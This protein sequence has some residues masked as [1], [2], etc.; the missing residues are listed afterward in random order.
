MKK[1][2]C[3]G[4]FSILFVH[5]HAQKAGRWTVGA[6]FQPGL[7]W[8]YN[9]SD[10]KHLPLS[11]PQ[12]HR[13]FNRLGGALTCGYALSDA[14]GIGAE[15][16][17]ARQ[18]QGYDVYNASVTTGSGIQY[19]QNA[20]ALTT[21]DYLR[22]PVYATAQTEIGYQS[23]L[24]LS[25]FAGPQLAYNTGY[26]S[27]F[28]QYQWSGQGTAV[29]QNTIETQ[30]TLTPGHFH[31]KYL[32]DHLTPNA[33]DYK[34]IDASTPWLYSRL[35]IGLLA[36]AALKKRIGSSWF[37]S[38]GVRYEYSL[39]NVENAHTDTDLKTI[40]FGGLTGSDGVPTPR[41]ATHNRSL[42]VHFGIS[43]VLE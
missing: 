3:L 18:H 12:N 40:T 21:L 25:V 24:F 33:A 16:G 31:E 6:D 32:T 34:I 30:I 36:G 28:T 11:S 7:Y 5:L 14:W 38:F 15:L 42:V 2:L 23:G 22:L 8:K 9:P 1:S 37:L 19:I 29:N 27:E 39:T 41:P 43:R 26:Q 13:K 20:H 10:W 4:L 17:F 35:E